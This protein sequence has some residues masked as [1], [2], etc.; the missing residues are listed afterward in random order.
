MAV[1]SLYADMTMQITGILIC[2]I[3]VVDVFLL[4]ETYAPTLLSNKARRMRIEKGNWAIHSKHEE[5]DV[6]FKEIATKYM[7]RP[8]MLIFLEPICFLM[9]LYASFVFGMI[10][11]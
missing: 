6:S 9:C 4:D 8:L 3:F 1:I 5:A 2:S 7:V 11:M 10:Y